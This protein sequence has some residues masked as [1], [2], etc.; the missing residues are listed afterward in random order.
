MLRSGPMGM[1]HGDERAMGTEKT[2]HWKTAYS[3]HIA[4]LEERNLRMGRQEEN[5]KQHRNSGRKGKN[6]KYV[7]LAGICIVAAAI[8]GG[9]AI[10]QTLRQKDG[11]EEQKKVA[12]ETITES[13][14]DYDEEIYDRTGVKL[15]KREIDW[16]ALSE[17]N[18]DI[19][20]W[21]YIPGTGV[22]YPVLQKE[23][24]DDY[25]LDHNLDK[26]SGYPGCI[27]SQYSYNQNPL[28]ENHTVLYGH[29]L[30]DGTMFTSLHNYEDEAFFEANRYMV[31]YTPEKTHVYEIFAAYTFSDA[32]LLAT[33]DCEDAKDFA[34][35]LEMVKNTRTENAHFSK[36]I[37][38][39]DATSPIVT[40]S[41]C[42]N[43][44]PKNRWL[45]CGVE[46]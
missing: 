24:D 16:E 6:R 27:Y 18:A 20:A 38:A 43:H 22:D 17:E 8:F 33:Y 28:N 35:Y 7:A 1:D 5:D 34:N 23:G 37:D 13:E 44:A 25:Y 10:Y 41:T 21:I 40:L 14:S 2:A 3:Q 32:H 30:K 46:L 12:E 36:E 4:V 15:P 31:I 29:N 11:G 19:Y 42:M 45:V 9:A 26:S 39:V